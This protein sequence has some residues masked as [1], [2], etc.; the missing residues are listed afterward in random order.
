MLP[1]R[2]RKGSR[3]AELFRF[4]AL[5]LLLGCGGSAP[6]PTPPP[7][8]AAGGVDGRVRWAG[9]TASSDSLVPAACGALDPRERTL[10]PQGGI[11]GAVARI[12]ASEDRPAPTEV[13]LS[14]QGCRYSTPALVAAPGAA[15]VVTHSDTLVHTFHLRDAEGASLQ[16]LAVPPGG[17]AI[18]WT[19]PEKGPVFVESDHFDWMR[20]TIEIIDRGTWAISDAE[21]RFVFPDAAAGTRTVL[22]SHPDLGREERAVVV[23][24]DG[25]AALYVDFD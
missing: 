11:A 1:V 12:E 20:A 6:A 16:N 15:L 13:T 3:R 24:P 9:G 17:T 2:G 18:R 5:I 25:P 19:L 8:T 23:P 7:A 21:G 4:S 22:L 10:G 14:A